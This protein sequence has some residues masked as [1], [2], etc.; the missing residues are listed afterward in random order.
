[1]L[2]IAVFLNSLCTIALTRQPAKASV[3]LGLDKAK[4]VDQLAAS[5]KAAGAK[6]T[7]EPQD[8]F[9]GD[10]FADLTDPFGHRW[11]IGAPKEG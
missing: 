10:R 7:T 8:M 4:Q 1:M 9:W 3:F 2:R 11:M 5:A 6:I